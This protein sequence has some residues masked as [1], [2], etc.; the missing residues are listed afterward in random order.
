MAD[1][2]IDL[3]K[4][5]N[6]ELARR[7]LG[8]AQG[9]SDSLS[10]LRNELSSAALNV[11]DLG[12]GTASGLGAALTAGAGV[13]MSAFGAPEAGQSTLDLAD[14]MGS[15]AGDQFKSFSDRRF[16]PSGGPDIS[17]FGPED[18]TDIFNDENLGI[19]AFNVQMPATKRSIMPATE[20]E[21]GKVFSGG[22]TESGSGSLGPKVIP[23]DVQGGRGSD[24]RPQ[25]AKDAAA[26]AV[27]PAQELFDSAFQE[28]ISGVRGAGPDAPSPKEL[29]DYKAEFAKA[30]GLDVS[31]NAD[32]SQ[33]LMAFGLAAMQNRAGK[34]FNVGRMLES[35]G[36]AGEKA[37][38]ALDKARTEA[39]A[40]SAAAGKYALE[41]RSSDKEK[42]TAA[43]EK[44]MQRTGYYVVPKSTDVKGFLAGV[45]EGKGRLE[46][47][48]VWELEKLQNN[49]DFSDKYDVLPGSMWGE[50]VKE[51][52]KTPE[53]KEKYLTTPQPIQ[54]IPGNTDDIFKIDLFYNEPNKN[55]NGKPMVV[56]DGQQQYE[57]LAR[58]YQ[59]NQKAKDEFVKL[60]VLNEGTNIFRYSL[61]SLNGLA[62]GFGVTFTDDLPE[63]Q[64]MKLILEKMAAKQAPRILGESGKTISDG[65]RERVKEIVGTITA[66][67]NPQE[68]QAKFSALFNDIIIG[69]EADINQA[70][71][72][73]NRY[74][75][76]NIGSALQESELSEDK[77]SSM[78]ADL[79]LLGVI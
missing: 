40:N 37:L 7:G 33:A 2:Q 8:A 50:I 70:L 43:K 32:T 65:D 74:T 68:L 25:I 13:G 79:K 9:I 73:L 53:A 22:V 27:S 19:P 55:P 34:G 41:M 12:K 30:T 76:R 35:L 59:D 3:V 64:K 11:W 21:A 39:R 67:S 66:T 1:P 14:R 17:G 45:S 38:P 5:R 15:F 72:T 6:A 69:S 56:G 4:I 42:A 18:M 61:D 29:E 54:L 62:A 52:M 77:R 16:G 71:S 58:M 23:S 28:Y 31:G 49:K 63:S 46:N 47:L 10:P 44:A 57:A 24:P 51:A 20:R 78:M 48:N 75:G 36:Q 26:A 60:G